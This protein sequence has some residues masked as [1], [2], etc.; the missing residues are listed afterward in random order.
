MEQPQSS[1]HRPAEPLE[2]RH[3]FLDTQVYRALGHNPENPA[4]KTLRDHIQAHRVVLHT[5]DITLFEV[6]RQLL[7][8]VQTRARELGAIEKDLRRWRKQAPN[9][10]PNRVLEIDAAAVGEEL[11]GQF[12]SFI[13]QECRA[14]LHNALTSVSA[15]EVFQSYFARQAP[16]DREDSKEFPDAFVV[17]ALSKWAASSGD[18]IHVVTGDGAMGRAANADPNLLSLKTIQEVLSRA[19]AQMGPEAEAIAEALLNAPGFDATFERLLQAG[20]KNAA[21]I[22]AGDLA[23]GEAYEG[24]LT[25]IEQIGCRRR[26]ESAF[27]RRGPA[28][29]QGQRPTDRG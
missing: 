20:V 13:T 3:V 25:D 1:K 5:T 17:A 9:A 6:K 24:E 19:A 28:F 27:R 26:R 23:E 16:F 29:R 22:Y 14:K 10:T 8:A 2:T 7:E 15:Q 11:F 4:L 21:F 12:R 18:K